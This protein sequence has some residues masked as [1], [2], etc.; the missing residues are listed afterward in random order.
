[1]A[2]ESRRTATKIIRPVTTTIAAMR[3]L[4]ALV[5]VV[6]GS[7]FALAA[8]PAPSLKIVVLEGEG[9]VNIIQQ[10][11]AVRPLVEVRDRNN[12][13]VAGASVTFSIGGGGSGAAFAGGVQTLTVTTNAA[14]QAAASG[15]NALSSGAFQIQVSA[16]YQGQ[17]ATAAISQTNFATA[18]AAAQAGA[19]AGG[20][21]T[22]TGA[23]G[24]A[25]GGGGGISGTTL[26][27]VGAAVAGGAVAATQVVGQSDEDVRDTY[28]GSLSGQML[29]SSFF[30]PVGGGATTNC[31][32]TLA[33][34][35]SMTMELDGGGTAGDASLTL[36]QTEVALTGPCTPGS[37]P[38]L[39]LFD[40]VV[41]GGPSALTF[42]HVGQSNAGGT[43][44]T[45]TVKFLGSLSGTTITGTV[46]LEIA[47]IGSTLS[48]NA[49]A[50]G[51]T[52]MSITLR[53]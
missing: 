4:A 40:A 26:G 31:V 38:P 51:S 11:T 16:A 45:T 14:G 10:K 46:G 36:N 37:P 43:Q 42:T 7:A 47:Q 28:T 44:G 35:G 1:M 50:S 52:T 9:A 2:V 6:F 39:S 20:G 13:P 18:A 8:Q 34:S 49:G 27:I 21:G 53:R 12:L 5:I 29:V 25:A 22:T 15:L 48:P 23:A 33:L 3:I 41:S 19:T 17:I 32:R 24:G 30:T